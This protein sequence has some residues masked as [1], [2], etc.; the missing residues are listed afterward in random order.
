M[1]KQTAM[2]L[3][4]LSPLLFSAIVSAES[5]E[6][7]SPDETITLQIHTT[8]A[9]S[10]SIAYDGVVMLQQA[11]IGL[12]L[13]GVGVLG[14][15]PTVKGVTEASEDRY[16]EPVVSRNTNRIHDA[17]RSI[18]IQFEQNFDLECRVY[19]E[20][21]AYRFVTHFPGSNRVTFEQIDLEFPANSGSFFPRE[22]SM[23]SHNE[24]IFEH[25][26]LDDLH[27]GD[28][29]SL[30][31]MITPETGP[32]MLLTEADLF[33][34]PALYMTGGEG[35]RLSAK[36]PAFVLKATPQPGT[37]DRNLL[38]EETADYIARTDG[39]RNYPWRVFII[40]EDAVFIENEL[41]YQ[42]SRDCE[43]KDT[44][45]IKPGRVAWDWYNANNLFGVDF[46]AGINT[47][48]YKHYID[49]A[50]EYGL[51]YIILDEGWTETTTKIDASAPEMDVQ[52]IIHYG[53][54]KGVGVIL[55]ALW[56]PIAKDRETLFPLY[57]KW[58]A[59]GVKIDFM[60]RSDQEMVNFYHDTAKLAAEHKL[61]VDYH[62]SFK[63]A[64]LRRA[65]PNVISYEGVKG[66]ENNKWSKDITPTHN[67]TLPF[68]RAAVG[69]MD[70]TPGAMV[71]KHLINHNVSFE[72]P[73]SIGTRAHEVAKYVVF[74]S[75]LQMLCDS[76]SLY[77]KE[78]ETT[79]FLAKIPSTWDETRVLKAA[80]SEY[81]LVARRK[82]DIWYVGA[83]TNEKAPR[84]LTIDWSFL[85]EGVFEAEIF[86]DGVNVERYAQD[87]RLH[88]EDLDSEKT[89]FK[90]H[91]GT[92]GGWAA[93]VQKKA[94]VAMLTASKTKI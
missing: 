7:K 76:P 20:G 29:C 40:G 36:H 31:V 6:L 8:P 67:V 69:P 24:R 49:F 25:V 28:F 87:Y 19:D 84:D 85:G 26:K 71:N 80:V 43:I 30:P 94:K 74:V 41:V 59:A 75:P 83:M 9:L 93:I 11:D 5:Y 91:L 46:E 1:K 92:G 50:A 14:R 47:R 3:S 58:G 38:I 73:E 60:Q 78:A 16:L 37:E 42:L 10:L 64:G 61:L 77:R 21:V 63:P 82:G 48:T 89:T 44:S 90:I 53:K 57:E 13:E 66:S 39:A 33:D 54:S 32:K 72:R 35:A 27:S 88:T 65:Y 81:V 18:T 12:A 34:Y 4:V 56:G 2:V 17:F 23:I 62:G 86:E 55:W 45:W 68:T 15:E 51:E 70:Y 52:E 79:A 22:E